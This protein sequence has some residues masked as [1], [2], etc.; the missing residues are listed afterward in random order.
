MRHFAQAFIVIVGFGVAIVA[1]TAQQHK[2][3]V[4]DCYTITAA[5]LPTICQ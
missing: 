2:P 3:A 1:A 5:S 4:G